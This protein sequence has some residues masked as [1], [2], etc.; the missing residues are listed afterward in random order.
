MSIKFKEGQK[1]NFCHVTASGGGFNFTTK[2]GK[3]LLV[4]DETVSIIS[5]K[6]LYVKHKCD[7]TLIGEPTAL[8][9]S[10]TEGVLK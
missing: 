10:V 2:V 7:V 4:K 3:I 6:K 9:K 5:R 1:V 8:T